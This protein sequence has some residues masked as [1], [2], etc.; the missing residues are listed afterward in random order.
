[1]ANWI[2]TACSRLASRFGYKLVRESKS[3]LK[4]PIPSGSK[5][6]VGCGEDELDGYFGCDLR[7]LDHVYLA[8]KAWEVSQFCTD[9]GEI[10][11]RHMVEHLTLE[12]AKLT[13]RDWYQALRPEGLLRIEV[14]NIE[15]AL[16]QWA[17]ADWSQQQLN[18]KFSDARWGF[19]GL[20]G[21]QRECDPL[22]EDYNQSYWDVHKSGYTGDSMRFF[23]SEAGFEDIEIHY[24][25]FTEAQNRRRK[26]SADASK[27]CHLFALARKPAVSLRIAA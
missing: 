27:D 26:L 13:L 1:M 7:P 20:F 14:P 3:F 23:L 16:R 8:C 15:F 22:E 9:L 17:R 21:W 25:G 12:E 19:A 18:D 5:L 2:E 10:Y 24:G 11:S 4:R 6:Y